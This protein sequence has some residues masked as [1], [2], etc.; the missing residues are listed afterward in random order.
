MTSVSFYDDDDEDADD[1]DYGKSN[2]SNFE[3]ILL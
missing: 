2:L 1:I 3:L